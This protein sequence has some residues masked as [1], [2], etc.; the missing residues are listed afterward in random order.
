VDEQFNDVI[1]N[2]FGGD[3]ATFIKTL[4]AQNLTVSQYR[5]QLRDRIIVQ[6]MRNRKS[7]QEVVASP[8]KIEKYYKEHLDDYNVDEQ[9]KLRM[10]SS[11]KLNHRSLSRLHQSYAPTLSRAS[12][13][14]STESPMSS[15]ASPT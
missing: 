9:I 2:D 7:M 8:Y 3:R 5:D 13:T 12:P 14:L 15:P 6:A 1:A 10:I 11:R 4:E